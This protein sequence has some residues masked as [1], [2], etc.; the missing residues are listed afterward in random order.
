VL[1]RYEVLLCFNVLLF[2]LLFEVVGHLDSSLSLFLALL[3]LSYSQFFI[4]QFPEFG[5]FKLFFLFVVLFSANSVNL[6]FP[7]SFNSLF[8]FKSSSLL[9][10]EKL[11]SFVF[12]LSNL[13]IENFFFLI[14][15]FHQISN[16]PID[17]C[18]LDSLFMLES[19][20]FFSLLQVFEGLFLLFSFLDS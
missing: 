19:L 7:A 11:S 6:V 10:F 1:L 15:D 14:P 4:S 18:L 20:F 16:L 3:L 2:S 5:K 12:G 17:Q 8:H 9:L 13:L